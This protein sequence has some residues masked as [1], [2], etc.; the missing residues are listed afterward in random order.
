MEIRFSGCNVSVL[1]KESSQGG[2]ELSE[3]L[4]ILFT[5][6]SKEVE[7]VVVVFSKEGGVC[8]GVEDANFSFLPDSNRHPSLL[9]VHLILT[10]KFVKSSRQVS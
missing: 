8:K 4:G 3:M 7:G 10:S 5:E 6:L 2:L 9:F 1:E